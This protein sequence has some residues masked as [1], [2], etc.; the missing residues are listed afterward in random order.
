MG[1]ESEDV[2]MESSSFRVEV[3]VKVSNVYKMQNLTNPVLVK[4]PIVPLLIFVII[5]PKSVLTTIFPSNNV[6]N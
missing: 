4:N 2:V 5:I 3:K 1:S 6:H